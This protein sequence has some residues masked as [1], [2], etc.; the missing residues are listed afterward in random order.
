VRSG[1]LAAAV[2]VPRRGDPSSALGG[3]LRALEPAL[4]MA[5]RQPAVRDGGD[6]TLVAASIAGPWM[7]AERFDAAVL[8]CD[9]LSGRDPS[10]VG[11][12]LRP[13]DPP[14]RLVPRIVE[15]RARIQP[16]PP[17]PPG[18]WRA[19]HELRQIEA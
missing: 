14:A 10:V 1:E 16:R 9:A 2:S 18:R 11:I 5:P 15:A 12:A 6:A 13:G 3:A 19:W 17:L 8:L 4:P 7:L